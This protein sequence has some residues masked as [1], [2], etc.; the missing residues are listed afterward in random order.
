[1]QKGFDKG[2]NIP[3]LQALKPKTASDQTVRNFDL[4]LDYYPNFS[5]LPLSIRDHLKILFESSHMK[6]V[7][8]Q[9]RSALEQAFLTSLHFILSQSG[10]SIIATV[11][12][13]KSS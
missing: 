9:D 13:L 1:M 6:K 10:N 2:K 7:F 4:I 5:G 12:S 11:C 3:R 8:S